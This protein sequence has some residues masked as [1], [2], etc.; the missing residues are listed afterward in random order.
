MDNIKTLINNVNNCDN[1]SN[2][3]ELLQKLNIKLID[4]KKNQTKLQKKVNDNNSRLSEKYK[5]L[6]INEL[7]EEFHK[8]NK[9]SDK[10]K[11]YET[12][13]FKIKELE[14]NL[15]NNV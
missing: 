1:I 4:E 11:I 3:I 9:L 13:N 10:I 14:T 7:K 6:S 2:R 8:I 5:N 15:F 12:I